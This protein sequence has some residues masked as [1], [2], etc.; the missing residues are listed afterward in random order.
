MAWTWLND[1]TDD[2]YWSS[3][4]FSDG[5]MIVWMV[6]TGSAWTTVNDGLSSTILY[7]FEAQFAGYYGYGDASPL[8]GATIR[9]I[10]VYYTLT[11]PPMDHWLRIQVRTTENQ[12][13]T[14][15]LLEDTTGV[16]EASWEAAVGEG[17]ASIILNDFGSWYEPG[18]ITRIDVEIFDESSGE[19]TPTWT[20]YIGTK[21]TVY[22]PT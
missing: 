15:T 14:Q 9:A 17:V 4:L 18:L 12:Y 5:Q 11:D 19:L 1:V 7:P 8:Y 6:W 10:R 22:D 16:Y 13:T 2:T 21:E 20:S 3:S